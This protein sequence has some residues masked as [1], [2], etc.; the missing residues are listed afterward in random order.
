MPEEKEKEEKKLGELTEELA[1][2]RG[3]LVNGAPVLPPPY[4]DISVSP[5]PAHAEIGR[6]VPPHD[7]QVLTVFDA[8]PLNARDFYVTDAQYFFPVV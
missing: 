2:E 1:Y 4:V 7:K 5:L 6:Y 3:E 8:R